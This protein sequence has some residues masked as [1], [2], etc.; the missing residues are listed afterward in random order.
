MYIKGDRGLYR[1]G[2]CVG[3]L[4]GVKEQAQMSVMHKIQHDPL[5]CYIR[6]HLHSRDT[7]V[8]PGQAIEGTIITD[9]TCQSG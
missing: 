5:W 2:S 6:L 4:F 8:H 7:N 3:K 1:L 9:E